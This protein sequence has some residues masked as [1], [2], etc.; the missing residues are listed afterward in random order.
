MTLHCFYCEKEYDF[1]KDIF[2]A[3]PLVGTKKA[4]N[5]S[6]NKSEPICFNCYGENIPEDK[7]GWDYKF[8]M[9]PEKYYI[10]KTLK[11]RLCQ[12]HTIQTD[13]NKMPTGL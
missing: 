13:R 3:F 9:F 8:R 5:V 10:N 2:F 4:P 12:E 7:W 11:Q 6:K 1:G